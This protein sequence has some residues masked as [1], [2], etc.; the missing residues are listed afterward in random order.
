MRRSR[1]GQL[2][3]RKQGRRVFWGEWFQAAGD[4]GGK[5]PTEGR[6]GGAG[7]LT[8]PGRALPAPSWVTEARQALAGREQDCW[9]Q[10]RRACLPLC[11]APSQERRPP[12]P[13]LFLP[14]AW[15]STVLCP[16]LRLPQKAGHFCEVLGPCL[17]AST[18]TWLRQVFPLLP[19]EAPTPRAVGGESCELPAC[20]GTGV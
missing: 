1:E 13:H 10:R 12:C 19:E 3:E 5:E 9:G 16:I 15:P 4:A 7:F 8:H 18:D 20:E 11:V 14:V 6:L 17:V 2:P